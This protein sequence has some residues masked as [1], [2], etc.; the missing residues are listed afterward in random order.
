MKPNEQKKEANQ[1]PLFCMRHIKR[2]YVI[3]TTW[4][5]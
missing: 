4:E 1:S 2:R 3:P 5:S